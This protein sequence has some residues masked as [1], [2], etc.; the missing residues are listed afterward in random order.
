[1]KTAIVRYK[2]KPDRA[3]ENI[4]LIRA[5]FAELESQAPAGLCYASYQLDDGLSF[6]HIASVDEALGGNPLPQLAAFKAFV[7]T[8]GARCDEPPAA[9]TASTV[10]VYPATSA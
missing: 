2:L 6:V 10:G 7:A 9:S 5:V 8:I 4:A 3:A 1:M